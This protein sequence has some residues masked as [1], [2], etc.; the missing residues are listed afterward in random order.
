MNRFPHAYLTSYRKAIPISLVHVFAGI[1]R[2]LGIEISPLNVLGVVLAHVV[3]KESGMETIIVNPSAR[4]E[5]EFVEEISRSQARLQTL[6]PAIAVQE[7]FIPRATR[8]MLGRASRNIVASFGNHTGFIN[9]GRSIIYPSLLLSLCAQ[10]LVDR[11]N[12][13]LELL[14]D[15][16][17]PMASPLDCI[18]LLR[19]LS[20]MLWTTGQESVKR[21]C[22]GVWDDEV[23]RAVK[24]HRRSPVNAKYF[25]GMPCLDSSGELCFIFSWDII[26]TTPPLVSDQPERDSY[27]LLRLDG[28]MHC[29]WCHGC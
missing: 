21:Y 25:I 28:T 27:H 18:F 16:L 29:M 20:P 10:L 17:K 19:S 12:D 13:G 1:G 23:E 8:V 7:H 2:R 15:T 11:H 14:A 4:A 6:Y 22:D 5:T 9:S 26:H 24:V 3:P